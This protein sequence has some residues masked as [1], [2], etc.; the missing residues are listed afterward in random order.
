MS[1]TNASRATA[2]ATE[3]VTAEVPKA[4]RSAEAVA[5]EMM[6]SFTKAAKLTGMEHMLKLHKK[7]VE[8]LVGA[9]HVLFDGA[10]AVFKRQ[11]EIMQRF[12]DEAMRSSA[13][14]MKVETDA[15]GVEKRVDLGKKLMEQA[16][17]DTRE[18]AEMVGKSQQEA[19]ELLNKRF[20]EALEEMKSV[21]GKAG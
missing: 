14:M 8:A 2:K 16:M 3:K 1:E 13:E 21:F 12:A 9:Q 5:N 11:M 4:T 6:D 15:A 10:T 17:A 7:N 19:L 18:L 20:M